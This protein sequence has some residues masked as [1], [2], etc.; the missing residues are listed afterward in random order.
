MSQRH[1]NET[2]ST[3]VEQPDPDPNYAQIIFKHNEKKY[4]D[5]DWTNIND[6]YQK[7]Y[8][9]HTKMGPKEEKHIPEDI[10]SVP[11]HV[12]KCRKKKK[13]KDDESKFRS[14]NICIAKGELGGP[15]DCNCNRH[16]TLNVPDLR[17][18]AELTT[19]L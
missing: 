19:T 4:H 6:P 11:S 16:F 12:T 15:L 9:I 1:A 13:L 17:H 10:Y 14:P 7:T 2:L 18:N 3:D 5:D 8:Y